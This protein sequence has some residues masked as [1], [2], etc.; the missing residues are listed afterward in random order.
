[1]TLPTLLER[2]ERVSRGVRYDNAAVAAG[3][4]EGEVLTQR[5]LR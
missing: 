5:A 2:K 3:K 1:M 4:K